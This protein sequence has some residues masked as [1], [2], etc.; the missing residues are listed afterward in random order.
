M[1]IFQNSYYLRRG[2]AAQ[3]IRPRTARRAAAQLQSLYDSSLSF[4]NPSDARGRI[5]GADCSVVSPI[6][7]VCFQYFCLI[8]PKVL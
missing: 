4:S 5:V 2:N 1:I 3:K 7:Q 6:V 8:L